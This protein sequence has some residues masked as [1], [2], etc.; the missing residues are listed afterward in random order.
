VHMLFL[1]GVGA[2]VGPLLIGWVSDLTGSLR[3]AM[4][5]PMV[6]TLAAAVGLWIAERVVRAHTTEPV[7]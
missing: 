7:R 1:A 6:A 4:L 2:A 3:V 5:V